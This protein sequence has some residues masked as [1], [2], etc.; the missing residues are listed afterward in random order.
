MMRHAA[1]RLPILLPLLAV[2]LFPACRLHAQQPQPPAGNMPDL[3]PDSPAKDLPIVLPVPDF[4]E[5]MFDPEGLLGCLCQKALGAVTCKPAYEYNLV[6]TV[7]FVYLFNSFYGSA[8][9]DFYCHVDGDHLLLSSTA[10]GKIRI[11]VPFE[12]DKKNQCVKA[13]VRSSMCDRATAISC[14][15]KKRK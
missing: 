9:Q 11:A 12:T 5:T 4:E 2:L 6:R 14:C 3:P 13:T 10:W 7:N 1:S 15:E 8:S